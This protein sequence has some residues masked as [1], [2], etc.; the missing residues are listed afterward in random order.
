[1]FK[2]ALF[3][4][5]ILLLPAAAMA[6]KTVFVDGN[7]TT[8][9]PGTRLTAA[10]LNGLQNHRHDGLDQDGSAPLDFAPDTSS[11]ANVIQ[12]SLTPPLTQNVV[13]MPIWLKVANTNTGPVTL[14]VNGLTAAA[15]FKNVSDPLAAG[16]IQAGQII[17]VSWA[18]SAYQLTNYQNQPPPPTTDASTLNGQTAA[19]LT[20]PGAVVGFAMPSVPSGWLFCDGRA[21]L[22][23]QFSGLFAAIGTTYGAGDGASTFNLPD[24]RGE[25]V[26]G[27]DGSGLSA[28]GVDPGR[29][30]GS[31]QGDQVGSHVHVVDHDLY[32][33]QAGTRDTPVWANTG[34]QTH[35][36]NNTS[37]FGGSETRP[38]NFPLMYCIKY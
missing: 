18:G 21:V 33:V 29:A 25:F 4:L 26:R 30:M 19:Q 35:S 12:I 32:Y 10:T 38:R 5:L 9:S 20:P 34:A 17:G 24:F 22:R 37:S 2:R 7:P 11:T 23:S 1:M 31:W 28:R 3:T 27:W 6:G 8:R 16:D 15:L 14:Q 36:P 13:G